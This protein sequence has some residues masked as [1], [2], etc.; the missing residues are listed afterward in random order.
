MNM[1]RSTRHLRFRRLT[2]DTI[3]LFDLLESKNP[4][5]DVHGDLSTF[6]NYILNR[7][8]WFKLDIIQEFDEHV[9]PTNMIHPPFP[10]DITAYI[11]ILPA[12]IRNRLQRLQLAIPC[13]FDLDSTLPT[14]I[15][16]IFCDPPG[17]QPSQF[18]KSRMP[19]RAPNKSFR[20]RQFPFPT[21]N[22]GLQLRSMV[23]PTC[24]TLLLFFYLARYSSTLARKSL[25]SYPNMDSLQPLL[26]DQSYHQLHLLTY[27]WIL[28]YMHRLLTYYAAPDSITYNSFHWNIISQR[29]NPR[30]FPRAGVG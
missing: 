3:P 19:Y 14:V 16:L 21:L 11:N 22:H 7:F 18:F 20:R 2:A 15:P 24:S 29:R 8:D 25:S 5:R 10:S 30:P 12:Y 13:E 17:S 23:L 6:Y 28:R 1:P 4:S 27:R 26:R 9:L